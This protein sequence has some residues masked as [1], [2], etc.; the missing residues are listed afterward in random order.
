MLKR[1]LSAYIPKT[2]VNVVNLQKYE[3]SYDRRRSQNFLQCRV[4]QIL[5]FET[6]RYLLRNAANLALG[7]EKC[8]SCHIR[9]ILLRA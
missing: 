7:T 9:T 5:R 1:M 3:N 8:M 4:L 6:D 2:R